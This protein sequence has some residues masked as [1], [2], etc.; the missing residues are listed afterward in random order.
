MRGA[1]FIDYDELIENPMREC[2][3]LC[4]YLNDKFEL[5]LQRI[6]EQTGVMTG[7][8][9]PSLRRSRNN[10]CL[11]FMSSAT[12]AQRALYQAIERRLRE[13]GSTVNGDFDLNPGGREY[14][15][16]LVVLRQLMQLVD[17]DK[18]LNYISSMP[19]TFLEIFGIR[20]PT[21]ADEET[22][23]NLPAGDKNIMNLLNLLNSRVKKTEE[24]TF[25]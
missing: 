2:Q 13:H 8:V 16:T 12:Q 15:I 22:W 23:R 4:R 19:D 14:L 21:G 25:S 5:S 24:T 3:R 11:D 10:G 17:S 6:D 1:L 20:S 18:L 9:D 7:A